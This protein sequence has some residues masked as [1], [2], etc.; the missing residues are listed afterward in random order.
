MSASE[1]PLSTPR[2][3]R[4]VR[5]RAL[6]LILPV[7]L[8]LAAA[9]V[10]PAQAAGQTVRV[11]VE[12]SRQVIVEDQAADAPDLAAGSCANGGT[13]ITTMAE[14]QAIGTDAT[15]LAGTYC[16]ADDLDASGTSMTSIGDGSNRFTGTFDGQGHVVANLTMSGS[17]YFGLFAIVGPTGSVTNL[18]VVNANVTGGTATGALAGLV[19]GSVSNSYST[20]SV[21][22]YSGVGGLVGSIYGGTS[23]AS[24]TNSYSTAAV[25]GN[26]MGTSFGGLVGDVDRGVVAHSYS[27]GTVSGNASARGLVG[28]NAGTVTD[29]YW[30]MDTSGRTTSAGGTGLTDVQM[31]QATS[32][33]GFGFD[34]AWDILDG[35][36]YPYL[37]WEHPSAVAASPAPGGTGPVGA[38]VTVAFDEAMDASSITDGTFYLTRSGSTTHVAGGLTWDDTTKTATLDPGTDLDL[39]ASFAVRVKGGA[40]GVRGATGRTLTS[41]AVWTFTTCTPIGSMA[42][43]QGIGTTSG[44]LSGIY[45]LTG[46]L[47]ASTFGNFT[48]IG[49]GQ[50]SAFTGTF[51]GQGH[52]IS[53]LTV[54]HPGEEGVGLFGYIGHGGLVKN[55]GLE[56]V[57]VVGG[58]DTGGLAGFTADAYGIPGTV[59][60]VENAYTTGSVTGTADV[61]GLVGW[62]TGTI[63]AS[64][65]T[66]SVTGGTYVGGLVGM[67]QGC[68]SGKGGVITSSY[69]TGS[70]GGSGDSHGGLAGSN[71]GTITG[72]HSTGSVSGGNNTGGLVG[73]SVG[74]IISS[75]SGAAARVTGTGSDTGGLVGYMSGGTISSCSS[76]A[77]VTGVERGTGGLVGFVYYAAVTGSHATGNVTAATGGSSWAGGLV[78]ASNGGSIMS[79]YST[80][81][82]TNAGEMAYTGGLVGYNWG[83]SIANGYGTGNVTGTGT[84]YVLTGGLVGFNAGS[85]GT[86]YSAGRV[87]GGG[88]YLPGTGGLVGYVDSGSTTSSYWDLDTSGQTSSAGGTGLT[89][90]QMRN[91]ASFGGFAFGTTWGIAG[92]VTYPYLAWQQPVI[93][94]V[95]PAPGATTIAVTSDITVTFNTTM[96]AS[97]LSDGTVYVT[98]TG[99]ASHVPVALSLSDDRRTVTLD[100]TTNLAGAAYTVTV[101]GGNDGVKS[102]AG[103]PMSVPAGGPAAGTWQWSF[104][105]VGAGEVSAFIV[106][107]PG[108]SITGVPLSLTVT[109]VD[110]NERVVTGYAGTVHFSSSDGSA[111]LP[112]D[113]VLTAGVG[114]FSAT[115]N[116][117]GS[118]TISATDATSPAITG[119]SG[120]IAVSVAPISVSG[121]TSSGSVWGGTLLQGPA[122][123]GVAAGDVLIA[124]VTFHHT[125][126][127]SITAPAGWSH[128]SDRWLTTS[129]YGYGKYLG[130]AV[131]YRV[132]Q[133]PEPTSYGWTFNTSVDAMVAITGFRGVDQTDPIDAWGVG[134]CQSSCTQLIAPSVTTTVP[135][136]QI[137]ALFAVAVSSAW[138]T[139]DISTPAT[140]ADLGDFFLNGG[141]V[142]SDGIGV[143]GASIARAEAGATGTMSATSTHSGYGWV[144]NTIALRPAPPP[145][146]VSVTS[147]KDDATYPAGTIID[148]GVE[149]TGAVTVSGS[150]SLML[151]TG[152]TDRTA[153]YVSGSGSR[154]LLFRY[155]VQ[156]GDESSDLDYAGT[157]ALELNGGTIADALGTPA[158]LA[159]PVPGS[160]GSLGGSKN[161]GIDTTSPAPPAA[162]HDGTTAGIDADWTTSTYALSANWAA[163][164]STDVASYWYAIG[165]SP[166]GQDTVAWT[167]AGNVTSISRSSLPLVVGTRY[168]VSVKAR[169]AV[170]NMSAVTTSDGITVSTAPR[171][172]G[173]YTDAD[174]TSENYVLALGGTVHTFASGL[175]GNSGYSYKVEIFG[176]SGSPAYATG[177]TQ[178]LGTATWAVSYTPTPTDGAG[179][180]TLNFYEWP[181]GVCS[182]SSS[183]S[184]FK[185]FFVAKATAYT[186]AALTTP[187]TSY[188][189]GATAYVVVNTVT[190]AGEDWNVTWLAPDIAC[191]NTAGTDRPDSAGYAAGDGPAGRLPNTAGSYLAYPPTTGDAWNTLANYETQTACDP[192][193]GDNAGQ[194]RLTL[195]HDPTHHV[196]LDAF[197]VTA[198]SAPVVTT[199]AT[200]PLYRL[201]P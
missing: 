58:L 42:E 127:A 54:N 111:A 90:V 107:A 51:D 68:C 6:A 61:G 153:G 195:Y 87:T 84:L 59:G 186:S 173:L 192:L 71:S 97:S 101:V 137:V 14:L 80:G 172:E 106:S 26:P 103:R 37:G 128:T 158:V 52:T 167:N 86:S 136:D 141:S 189:E 75:S 78:G 19:L 60:A 11:D 8:V 143:S 94:G 152:P 161:I 16:L 45:C 33:G 56:D 81:T 13:P 112:T 162:V 91:A 150:P 65:S 15:T 20:G 117:T 185:S 31:R 5:T 146:V 88:G 74:T 49:T 64:H 1:V 151:E 120:S 124:Q 17:A 12:A 201:R 41:D 76:G 53:N 46:D 132:V 181:N 198:N 24:V 83:G 166:G 122:V 154:T 48:P 18:G 129:N 104:S 89:D 126:G 165:T 182:G 142:L 196:T 30:N 155:T 191:A 180:Y 72:S 82:V 144:T 85:V 92:G 190:T 63:T 113:A 176:P 79:S 102:A 134:A 133:S 70:V 62:N 140:M 123:G 138:S 169:D 193:G 96:A 163:S 171:L 66:A 27:T 149:F 160:S 44:P 69:G 3:A 105:T 100:P 25:T 4:D 164:T 43:L 119:E 73:S 35:A 118:H 177:C 98:R 108:N 47:D 131:F 175:R 157:T 178:L 99:I 77:T 125:G 21:S 50:L 36:T 10:P 114:T 34:G 179:Y 40:G 139:N 7:L 194:W 57:L 23:S 93:T 168:Y 183:S 184:D 39:G 29:S 130:Q 187:T 197:S 109:A 2:S 174:R 170:G 67:N 135:K 32:F 38:N 159:L 55:I 200:S 145:S 22:G 148:I 188:S 28:A 95:T 110:G 9:P 156:A 116:T 121:A 115:L 199:T 147:S